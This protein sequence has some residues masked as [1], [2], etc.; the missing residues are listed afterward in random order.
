MA[1]KITEIH[2]DEIET[3]GYNEVVKVT[4]SPWS[5]VYNDGNA[6]D[7]NADI[8]ADNNNWSE[9]VN[10]DTRKPD[11]NADVTS[12]H[13]AA[14]TSKIIDEFIAGEDITKEDA[15]CLGQVLDTT[16]QTD[17]TVKDAY[18]SEENADTN[19]GDVSN[20]YLNYVDDHH[21]YV[22]IKSNIIQ[23]GDPKLYDKVYL[24][25]YCSTV[26]GGEIRLYR[27]TSD[28]EEDEI[29]WNN[30]P[31]VD[32]TKYWSSV[33]LSAGWND[34]DITELYCLWVSGLV[35]NHGVKATYYSA[36]D[37]ETIL[38]AREYVANAPAIKIHGLYD[39]EKVFKVTDSSIFEYYSFIG[40]AEETKV[41]GQTIKV[42]V[43]EYV[44]LTGLTAGLNYYLTNTAGNISGSTS[45]LSNY[46]KVGFAIS[47]TELKIQKGSPKIGG[48]KHII[49][50][51]YNIIVTGIPATSANF[52]GYYVDGNEIT[53]SEGK[54]IIP[55]EEESIWWRLNTS[56]GLSDVGIDSS[57]TLYFDGYS[58]D[59]YATIAVVW[60]NFIV[61][62]WGGTISNDSD[63]V[64]HYDITG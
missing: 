48:Q 46:F 38:K 36:G 63:I 22:Y 8:T 59:A 10:D 50:T 35:T 13:H 30:Q 53:G 58:H 34:I 44:A 6:P 16:F 26:G 2:P 52:R 28:W 17:R 5:Q 14:S 55:A 39:M 57:H 43:G 60:N 19:Y 24:R 51:G 11:D 3:K 33:V 64:Y 21:K 25:V 56:G 23:S 49:E 47:S 4:Q 12:T 7:D 62:I 42:N 27:V 32:E 1:E 41:S 18:I 54:L 40:F 29:T 45:G 15:L 37:G 9:V 61:T 31:T 20:L